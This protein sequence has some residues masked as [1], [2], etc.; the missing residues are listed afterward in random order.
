[1]TQEGKEPMGKIYVVGIGPGDEKMMTIRAKE[2][3]DA[4]DVIAGYSLYIDLVRDRYPGKEFYENGMRGE[5]ER[6]RACVGMA[7]AGKTVALICSGDAGVY[8]MASPLLEA[9]EREDF[10]EVEIIPGVT[11]AMSG[12]AVLGAPLAHD[13]CV[14]SLSDLL[15]PWEVIEKRLL[16]AA[17]GDFC[18]AIYN[19]ASH[20]RKDYLQ[21]AC[22]LL[23]TVLSPDTCC[24]YVRNIGR[25]GS[26]R[27]V[28]RLGELGQI[29]ADML[30]TVYIGNSQ[31][32]TWD[33]WLITPRGYGK[34]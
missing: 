34:T 19:P 31:T 5:A 10:H 23:L 12:G 15:T 13:F 26:K 32:R 11:A 7:K 1:M 3:L 4:C 9:A 25:A 22:E 2:V 17:R 33:G 24:G 27:E 6:C 28:C 14:I 21:K 30:T 29:G 8:G 18:M 20:G 16:C